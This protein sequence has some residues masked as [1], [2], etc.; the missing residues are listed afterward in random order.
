MRAGL[1]LQTWAA[2]SRGACATKGTRWW[3]MTRRRARSPPGSKAKDEERLHREDGRLRRRRPEECGGGSVIKMRW[4]VTNTGTGDAPNIR[5]LWVV[6]KFRHIDR[7]GH[8]EHYAPTPGLDMAK[9]VVNPAASARKKDGAGDVV[10]A[11]VDICWAYSY[12]KAAEDTYIE[13]PDHFDPVTRARKVG[14]LKRCLYGTRQAAR[15]SQRE[16]EAGVSEVGMKV[17]D[18]S[19]CVFRSNCGALVGAMLRCD[20]VLMAGPRNLV[21]KASQPAS[22]SARRVARADDLGSWCEPEELTILN[23]RVQWVREGLRMA[24]DQ[25]CAAE[26]AEELGLEKSKLVDAPVCAIA[27]D[28][29]VEEQA[30]LEGAAVAHF[31]RLA[32]KLNYL[33]MGLLDI[34]YGIGMVCAVASKPRVGDL[35]RM[36]HI[37]RVLVGN[38]LLWT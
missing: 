22:P 5:A 11:A 10:L 14:K 34:R 35:A 37:A 23:R 20:D 6:Q 9:A 8:G 1:Q 15:A 33:S 3:R 12:A 19:K 31:R 16:L 29:A 13:V 28:F 7:L 17:G 30:F 18:M 25:R 4:V 27:R 21:R 2:L 24:P 26:V 32:A 36:N 38:P